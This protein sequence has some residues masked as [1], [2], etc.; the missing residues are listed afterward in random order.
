[1]DHIK[2]PEESLGVGAIILNILPQQQSQYHI[3]LHVG[4]NADARRHET[5]TGCGTGFKVA[6]HRLF[7]PLQAAFEFF[8]FLGVDLIL[9]PSGCQLVD[10]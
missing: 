2:W 10:D 3:G 9:G 8:Q 6:E 5:A 1:M 4:G 7:P